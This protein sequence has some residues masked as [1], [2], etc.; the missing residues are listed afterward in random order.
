[1]T[2]GVILI[3]TRKVNGEMPPTLDFNAYWT[4]QQMTRQPEF[5]NAEQYRQLVQQNKPGAVDFGGG[6]DWL[7]QSTQHPFSQVYNLS[8]KGGSRNT[9]YIMSMEY[10]DLNGVMQRSDNNVIYPRLEINHTMFDGVL[11]LNA[12]INGY[13]QTH[14]TS[15][16]GNY[17]GLIYR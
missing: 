8:L 3:T 15:D 10:R 12:N 13:Q 17:S 1:G 14:F 11:K 9:N 4:T 5:M 6:T 7:K 16:G 2:N